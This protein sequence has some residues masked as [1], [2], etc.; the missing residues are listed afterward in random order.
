MAGKVLQKINRRLVIC[1]E[2]FALLALVILLC[3]GGLMWRLSQ[4]PLDID[5]LSDRLEQS[6][7]KYQGKYVFDVGSTN[8]VW[9]GRQEPFEIEMKEV[10]IHRPDGTPVARVEKLGLYLSKRSLMVGE[11]APKEIRFYNPVLRLIRWEDGHL[12]L[13]M[14]ENDAAEVYGPPAPKSD[15]VQNHAE[16]IQA[17]LGQLQM[18]EG[19]LFLRKLKLIAIEDAAVRY[20]DKRLGISWLSR[21][22]DIQFTRA[23]SGILAEALVTIAEDA[24][25]KPVIGLK[26][27]YGWDKKETRATATFTD[28][29]LAKLAHGSEALKILAGLDLGVKGSLNID[30][31]ADF[32]PLRVKMA[33]SAGEGSVKIDGVH[34]VPMPVKSAYV[35]GEADI[36]AGTASLDQIKADLGVAQAEG[37]VNVVTEN[38]AKVITAKANLLGMPMDQLHLYWPAGLTPDPR[39][40]VTK[41]LSHGIVTKAT[42]D[43]VMA[44]DA[45]AEKK[46]SLRS[47]GGHIDYKDIKVDYY[48]PLMP[49][50]GATGTADYDAKSF[51][52]DIVSGSLGDM[53][54][55]KSTIRITDLDKADHEHHARIDI[56]VSLSGPVK[57]AL[58]VLDS[59]PLKYPTALGLQADTVSGMADVDVTFAFPLH[60]ALDL[61][62]VAVTAKAQIK[63][64][65]LQNVAAGLPLTGGDLTLS[66]E[67]GNLG[68]KG[69]GKLAAMPVTFDWLKSFSSSDKVSSTLSAKLSLDTPALKAFGVPDDLKL[70]GTLPSDVKY[71]QMHDGQEIL[72]LKSDLG[73]VSYT[74]PLIDI[75]KAAGQ[76][77]SLEMEMH[78]QKGS[79]ASIPSFTLQ[80]DAAS[81]SGSAGFAGGSLQKAKITGA[82]FGESSFAFDFENKGAAGYNVNMT[83]KQFDASV[84]FSED[85]KPGNDALAA[86]KVTPLNLK[87]SVDRLMTGKTKGM[88]G[89]RLSMKRNEWQRIDMLELD[90][91]AGGKPLS[92]RYLPQPIGHSL[93]LEA[94][95]AGAALSVLGITNSVRGGKLVVD[96]KTPPKG[97]KR[98]LQGRAILGDFSL[99][100]APVIAKLLNAMSLPG[101]LSLLSGESGMSFKKARVNFTWTD[102]GQ[103]EQQNN[104]RLIG[105]KDG[106]TSGAS[107]GLT[108]GGTIDNWK[109]TYNLDGT[110]IPVSDLN[111]MLNV[112]P[113]VG[114]I[115]TAGGEGIIAATYTI[116]GP[117]DQP[118]VMVNPLSVLAP[119]ILR[120]IFF[121]N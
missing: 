116:K 13:N 21:N 67:G 44:Y 27:F 121:E 38:G 104:I 72:V 24:L 62:E 42:L 60:H 77:G 41:Y 29:N 114:Q 112:I 57:T 73:P 99:K 37:T 83:G 87:M 68:I 84:F 107:L 109:N 61:P 115:L 56:A 28:I 22:T 23:R 54:V 89:V 33:A 71:T 103:P 31:D 40:W 26:V 8:M 11:I 69:S 7:N 39:A 32:M 86:K 58:K 51:N 17:L 119:G 98:D 43:L 80:S 59:D 47:L 95:N 90:A 66:L 36:V 9:A 92:V 49:V 25:L 3:W 74:L 34:D 102:R 53:A 81:F 75:S 65:S 52:L 120:K 111:K 4:G 12:T 16:V 5:F 110:I 94:D 106:Q 50:T 108:F 45:A 64:A 91:R 55:R 100:D 101:L 48:P 35:S 85:E 63:E 10:R 46:V 117:K 18:D 82:R 14:D 30:L 15:N 19:T 88:E 1:L 76:A 79:L 118:A 93:R 20:E 2:V 113:I 96:G 78:L 97:G 70:G 105:L 6:L